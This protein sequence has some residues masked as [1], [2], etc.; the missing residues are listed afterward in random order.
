MILLFACAT[1]ATDDSKVHDTADTADADPAAEWEAAAGWAM[2]DIP[3]GTFLM[4]SP[5]DEVGRM[6]PPE[7]GGDGTDREVQH[8]VTLTHA[9][10]VGVFEV[11]SAQYASIMG[12]DPTTR[13]CEDASC[14]V[15]SLSWHQ[16]AAFTVAASE[17][18]GLT[19]CYA[20]EGDAA[21][22]TCAP[23]R[24][25]YA[26]SGYRLPTEAEWEY[27]GR[28]GATGAFASGGGIPEGLERDCSEDLTLDNGTRMSDVAW[29]CGNVTA[30]QPAGGRPPNAW[31][32]YDITGN[33]HEW[34]TDWYSATWYLEPEANVPDPEGPAEGVEKVRRGGGFD[35]DP[36]RLRLAYRGWHVPDEPG[37][38]VGFRVVR[39]RG[40]D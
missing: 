33:V 22:V 3:P 19:A 29:W 6:V 36:W 30:P 7:L 37:G 27:Y 9:M 17:A 39:L 15:E 35:Y 11:G 2:A 25:P 18:A 38:N 8:E 40:V 12:Y 13:P 32:L 21:A 26:C 20:C 10:R 16:A 23:T 1:P 24:S 4:G 34:T 5:N 31:G 28:A 14:P